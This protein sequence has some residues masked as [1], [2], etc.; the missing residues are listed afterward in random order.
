M[1]AA[2]AAEDAAAVAAPAAVTIA[3][4]AAVMATRGGL[5]AGELAAGGLVTG[6]LAGGGLAARG[7]RG[8]EKRGRGEGGEE[9]KDEEEAWGVGPAMRTSDQRW[10]KRSHAGQGNSQQLSGSYRDLSQFSNQV[11]GKL[12]LGL[13]KLH[14]ERVSRRRTDGD[15]V[16]HTPSYSHQCTS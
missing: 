4:A 5:A 3:S 12:E 11:A 7:R 16:I 13:Q 10:T 14:R 1:A 6:G 2:E 9:K 15:V 8:L